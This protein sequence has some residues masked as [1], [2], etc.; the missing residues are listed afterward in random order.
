M[1]TLPEW[2]VYSF[3]VLWS[4]APAG[5]VALA[6]RRWARSR[7]QFAGCLLVL[8]RQ[9]GIRLPVH[10]FGFFRKSSPCIQSRRVPCGFSAPFAEHEHWENHRGV[11]EHH[12]TS[13]LKLR[14]SEHGLSQ[15]F[16]IPHRVHHLANGV[17][18]VRWGFQVHVVSGLNNDLPA[19]F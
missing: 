19:V 11:I 16:M 2:S 12:P 4:I 10:P 3:F 7:C 6:W 15:L 14:R 1:H 9:L 8:L 13:L 18:H 5:L 17:R